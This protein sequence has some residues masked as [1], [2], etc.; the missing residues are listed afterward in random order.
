MFFK[1][2]NKQITNTLAKY[3]SK[4]TQVQKYLFQNK[5]SCL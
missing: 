3:I 2:L 1:A 4:L 5:L